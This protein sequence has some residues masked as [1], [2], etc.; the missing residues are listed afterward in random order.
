MVKPLSGDKEGVK[1][2]YVK[3]GS[4][5]NQWM[6]RRSYENFKLLDDQLHRC[7]YDRKFSN[8]PDLSLEFLVRIFTLLYSRSTLL[9]SDVRWT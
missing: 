2:W 5:G 6:I 9:D 7:I 3:V 8:L 4:Q 1:H